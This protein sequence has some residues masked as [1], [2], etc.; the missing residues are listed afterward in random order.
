MTDP[1]YLQLAASLTTAEADVAAKKTRVAEYT[2]RYAELQA[3][4]NAVPQIEAEYT[5]LTRDYDVNKARYD[6]LL[7]RRESAEIT[8]D[9]EVTDAAMG[10]RVIDPP[11]LPL[12]P[13]A[14][15]RPFLMTMVLFAALG[16]GLGIAFLIS[17]LKPTIY[18]ERRLREVTG[19]A[20]LGTVTM[21]WTEAQRKRR[22]RWLGAFVLSFLSLISAYVAIMAML[23]LTVSRA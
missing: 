11:Q 10:F 17:Q 14:P 3:A 19:L 4:A 21:S 15:N 5:Q 12:A 18:D 13:V 23:I 22:A 9:M 8:G 20:V 1:A 2:R 16:S 6:E 7:R